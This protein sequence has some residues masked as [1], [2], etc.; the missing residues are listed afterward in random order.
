MS[1][2]PP[3]SNESVDSAAWRDVYEACES[4]L[5]AFLRSRL[6]QKADVDD[7]L[8]VVVVKMLESG[9]DVAPVARRAW[10]FRVAAN[11][12]ARMWRRKSTTKRILEKQANDLSETTDDDAAGQVIQGETNDQL[13]QAIEKLPEST[14]QIVRLRIHDNLTFQ[15]IADQLNI[16]LGTA[17]TRMR[18]AL[19]RLKNEIED[20]E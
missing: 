13:R 14:Q 19:E 1:P 12:S 5:R 7:C 2:D 9:G 16:P 18:R 15:Q 11:E 3:D 20:H 10:L 4:G 6:G 8:Q 17:L